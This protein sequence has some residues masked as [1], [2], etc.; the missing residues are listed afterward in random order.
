MAPVAV[1]EEWA[2]SDAET[3]KA[4]EQ[5]MREGWNAWMG[6]HGSSVKTTE[7]LGKNTSVTSASAAE[8][9]N[10][11]MLYSMVEA[12]SSEAAASLFEGHPH[13]S[14]PGASI[15]IMEASALRG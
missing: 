8:A 5:K 2:K 6:K 11:M 1:L 4:E 9:K 3:K 13:L 15:E 12:E 7:G 10:G 14:I